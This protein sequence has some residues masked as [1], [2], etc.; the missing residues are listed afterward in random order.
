MRGQGRD[1]QRPHDANLRQLGW[2]GRP[3]H[4]TQDYGDEATLLTTTVAD[5][6]WSA[7]YVGLY[8]GNGGG[9]QPYDD[10]QGSD[11]FNSNVMSLSYDA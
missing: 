2:A 9:A 4:P 8:P 6:T 5:D 10:V 3:A 7:G 1:R 11:N